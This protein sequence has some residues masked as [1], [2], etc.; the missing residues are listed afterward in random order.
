MRVCHI[1]ATPRGKPGGLEKHTLDLCGELAGEHEVHLVADPGFAA[2][3]PPGVRFH[4]V[5]FR[6]SRH[7]P[8]LY[9]RILR[10]VRAIN[11]DLVHAQAGKSATVWR[12]LRRLVPGLRRIACVGTQHGVQRDIAPYLAMDHVITVS[13]TLAER[14]PP[15][16][17]TVVHNG[18]RLPQVLAMPEREALRS[19][20]L[21]GHPGP[22]LVAIGRLDPVKGFDLL[23]QALPGI[24]GKLLLVG[25][26]EQR[27]A[28]ETQARGLGLENQVVFT[29]WRNDIP[30]LLQAADLCV[31]SSRSEGF[32]LVMVEALHAGTPIIA[33]DVSG[34]RELLPAD[35]RVPV[36]DAAA[37]HEC[38]VARVPEAAALRARYETL[39]S[40]AREALTLAGMAARTV[41]VYRAVLASRPSVP[42]LSPPAPPP[43][44]ADRGPT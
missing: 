20:L 19:R 14:Y 39:F 32:P 42:P 9:L 4:P 35:L 43:P 38:L 13:A 30:A 17:V 27:A 40:H 33:T 8:L 18:L 5:D 44:P 36:G 15:E 24:P 34:V 7:N 41:A 25:D 3:C 16:R 10:H 26:G 31:I 23:L 37:L 12:N 6:M 28:L 22:L 29:G 2:H 11:P 1:L 21:D